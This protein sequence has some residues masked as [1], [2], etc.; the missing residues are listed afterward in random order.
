QVRYF[1]TAKGNEK[2]EREARGE[3][4][5]IFKKAVYYAAETSNEKVVVDFENKD[6]L[7]LSYE[8]VLLKLKNDGSKKVMQKVAQALGIGKK[9]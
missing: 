8:D 6:F 4:I 7:W 1:Y 5:Y 2:R 3:G 9:K